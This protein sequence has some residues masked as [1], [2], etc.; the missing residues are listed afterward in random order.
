MEHLLAKEK[1]CWAE[2]MVFGFLVRARE[3]ERVGDRPLQP[4]CVRVA[5]T[6]PQTWP[7]VWREGGDNLAEGAMGEGRPWGLRMPECGK[8]RVEA[9][10][11][12][13]LP[14]VGTGSSG[15]QGL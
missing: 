10:W 2:Q 9:R 1:G 6:P 8:A 5:P 14:G 4:E 3:A 7:W 11:G 12:G 13:M 15:R